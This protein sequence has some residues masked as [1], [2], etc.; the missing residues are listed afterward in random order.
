MSTLMDRVPPNNEDAEKSVLGSMMLDRDAIIASAELLHPDDFYREA[1]RKIFEAMLRLFDR[2]EA[3]DLVT[4]TEELGRRDSLEAV[5]GAVY[6]SDIASSVPTAANI[7]HYAKIVEQKS[8]LR[9]LLRASAEINRMVYSSA[10]DPQDVLD[11]SEQLIFELAQG[12][13]GR[14]YAPLEIILRDTFEE[15]EKLYNSKGD[16]VGVPT[17]F[18]RLDEMTSG[19][20]PSELII[21]AA[22]PSVGKTT[23]ALNIAANAAIGYGIPVAIFSLEMARE[24]LAMRLLASEAR[25]D[26]HRLRSGYLR[27]EDWPKLSRALGKLSEVEIYVDDSPTLSAMELRGRARRMKA[28]ANVGLILVDYLQ[29][30][31]GTRLENRQQEISEISRSLKG[32]AREL[33]CPVV[34]LS[35]LSRAVEQRSDRRPQLSDLRE[36]GAIEQDADLVTFLWNNPENENENLM[37]LVIAKQRN[38]PTGLINLIFMKQYSRFVEPSWREED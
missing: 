11:K 28:E 1:H 18:R 12:R 25:I 38:G 23:L 3:V 10:D 33:K 5:G 6:I 7:E 19:L 8:L 32:L 13:L 15:I 26:G 14:S 4:V 16:V 20:H 9:R 17:G 36:S 22:R 27:D 37:D 29:L 31:H 21:I 34:A 30:M 24:Q 2:G 35:Q